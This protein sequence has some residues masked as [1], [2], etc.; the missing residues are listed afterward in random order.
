MASKTLTFSEGAKGWPSFYS[1]I[2]DYMIGMNNYFYSF[3]G[4]NLYRHNTNETRNNFYGKQYTSSIKSVFNAEPTTVKL[5]KT[6]E[7]EGDSPWGVTSTTNLSTGSINSTYFDKKEGRYYAYIRSNDGTVNV[8]LRNVNGIGTVTTV[9]ATDPAL[10][11][12]TYPTGFKFSSMISVGDL[13]YKNNSG[14]LQ[15]LGKIVSVSANIMTIDTTIIGG[16][17]PVDSDFILYVKNSVAE[18]YGVRGYYMEFELTNADTT[19]TELFSV[20]SS[21]FKSFP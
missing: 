2:P 6:I 1:Y 18:S 14:T 20:G 7:I 12:L 5:F 3:K 16:S 10:T 9:D 4:G 11:T 19:A 17:T 21:V 15:L 8:N 13:A